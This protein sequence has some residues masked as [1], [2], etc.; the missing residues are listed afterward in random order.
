MKLQWFSFVAAGVL[1]G[2]LLGSNV[3]KIGAQSAGEGAL[4]ITLDKDG[5]VVSVEGQSSGNWE[6]SRRTQSTKPKSLG[7]HLATINIYEHNGSTDEILTSGGSS[8]HAHAGPTD[9][10]LNAHCHRWANFSTAFVLT[11]CL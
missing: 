2:F 4:R 3:S 10:P 6:G 5:N 11:H 1:L 9:G 7:A 8:D